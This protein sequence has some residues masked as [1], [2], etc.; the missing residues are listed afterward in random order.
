MPNQSYSDIILQCGEI[1]Y[2]PRNTIEGDCKTTEN[3]VKCKCDTKG[4]TIYNLI[5]VTV[6][7]VSNRKVFLKKIKTSSFKMTCIF[8]KITF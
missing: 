8:R 5:M 1:G 4:A 7:E 6:K 2:N 3:F